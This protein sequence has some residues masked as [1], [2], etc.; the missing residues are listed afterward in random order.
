MSTLNRRSFLTSTLLINGLP[1]TTWAQATPTPTE[2]LWWQGALFYEVFV[3]A[4]QDSDGDGIGD[5]SGLQHR[6]DYLNDGSESSLGVN[7]IWLMPIFPSP[8]YHGYDVT[9][10]DNVN[11]EFGTNDDFRALVDA[12]HARDM[13]VILDLPINH[14]SVEHPWFIEAASDPASAKR[15]WYIFSESDPGY[16]GPWGEKVWHP[17]PYGSGFYYGIFDSAMPDLNFRNFDVNAEVRRITEFWLTDMGADGFRMDAIKHVIEEGQIQE[18]TPET[19]AWIETFAGW[20]RAAKADAF[21]IGEVMGSGTDGIQPYYPN[22][23]DAFFHFQLAQEI[24]NGVNFGNAV[25]IRN[26]ANG[27]AERLPNQRWGTFLT[28]HDQERIASTLDGDVAKLG[29]AAMILLSLPGIPFIYYGEEIGMPG[30]KP[31]PTIRTPMQWSSEANAGFT[32]GTPFIALQPGW[33]ETNVAVQDADPGSLLNLYRLWAHAR[34]QHEALRTG[35]FVSFDVGQRSILAFTRSTPTE[36][37]LVAINM[38]KTE[39][40]AVRLSMGEGISTAKSALDGTVIAVHGEVDL[41]IMAAQSGGI[42]VLD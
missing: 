30:E 31:D 28:N 25:K 33:E 23:L 32:T 4:F 20:V 34:A 16:L 7:G 15:D 39:S 29:V 38:G 26:F 13:R 27:A 9:D 18:G 36:S 21:T 1:L 22:G 35:D 2:S 11:P 24:I 19:I 6:L 8:S 5:F 14:T 40:E 41:G 3:R 17:N 10:Y 42:W 37:I 12:L